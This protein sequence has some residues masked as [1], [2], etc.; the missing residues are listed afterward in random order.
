MSDNVVAAAVGVGSISI[1]VAAAAKID[2]EVVLGLFPPRAE[3]GS[4][5]DDAEL[6]MVLV[7]FIPSSRVILHARLAFPRRTAL[8]DILVQQV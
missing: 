5:N 4:G 2:D 6:F 8:R 7:V 1:P 3:I